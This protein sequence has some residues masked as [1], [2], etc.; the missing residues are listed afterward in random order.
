MTID[1][2]YFQINCDEVCNQIEKFIQEMVKKSHTKGVV[3]GLSGGIDSSVVAALAVRALGKENVIGLILP[4]ALSEQHY[5]DDARKLAKQL[6]IE[7]KKISIAD[8]VTAFKN[9]ADEDLSKNALVVGNAMARFR[10]VLLYA[11]SNLLNYLVIGTSNKT[12]I[13]V[14]YITKYGDGGVDFEPCGSLYKTQIRILADYLKIPKELITKAPSAGLW[15]GQT[16]EGELGIS[17]ANLDLILLALEK[18]YKKEQIVNELK[19]DISL[20][21]KVEK[22]IKSSEHKRNMPPIL[23][24]KL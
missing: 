21:E 6:G 17:Y 14:G 12:E 10:M 23:E 3:I 18:G 20:I 19:L 7:V 16:D 11:Y 24:L 15:K 8:F 5:E 9:I 2:S 4:S 13:M 1:E 22:M